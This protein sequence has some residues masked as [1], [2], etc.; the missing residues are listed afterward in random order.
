MWD[1][2][3]E[4]PDEVFTP[5]TEIVAVE[6]D[7][8]VVRAHVHYGAPRRQEYRNLWLVRFDPVGRCV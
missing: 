8:A 3:R 7:T 1:D 2:D 4:G 6:S 5:S